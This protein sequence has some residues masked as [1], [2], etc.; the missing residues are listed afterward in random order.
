[1]KKLYVLIC[2]L[3]V[4]GALTAQQQVPTAH[5]QETS[6]KT[7][8]DRSN[9]FV[10][11][12]NRA[13]HFAEDFE[14][15]T[16]PPT[17]WTVQ[18]GATSTIT[19]PATQTWHDNANG[20]PGQCASVLYDN[21][22][23]IHDEWLMTPAI[24]I[25]NSGGAIRLEF[26][27]NTSQFWH[28]NPNDNADIKCFVS[29]VGGTI[30]DLAAGTEVFWEQDPLI[31]NE[32]ATFEWYTYQTDFTAYAGQTV[33][34]GWH[35]LGQDGAQFNLD[36]ISIYDVPPHDLEMRKM[37]VTDI[38]ADWEIRQYDNA[39]LRPIGLTGIIANNGG[40]AQTN[41]GFDYIIQDGTGGTVDQGSAAVTTPSLAPGAIDT[42]I[43][44][45]SYTPPAG[46]DDYTVWLIATADSV[47]SN[48]S[49]DSISRGF[50]TATNQW[51]AENG[52]ID[53]GITNIGGG[54]GL[55]V[56]FGNQMIATGDRDY[57]GVWLGFG[58]NSAAQTGELAYCVLY[59]F[60]TNSQDFIFVNQTA[61]YTLTGNE[62]GNYVFLPWDGGGFESITNGEQ[63]LLTAAHYGG[64][65][66]V[67]FGTSGNSLEGQVLG[68][69]DQNSL[70]Q[71]LDP[72]TI[73]VRLEGITVS[74]EENE[75][76]VY[77]GQSIPN[78]ATNEI[79]IPYDMANSAQVSLTIFDITGKIVM[80]VNKG[81]QPAGTNQF[82]LNVSN[83]P[84]GTYTYTLTT[85]D[86]QH[87]KRMV[88]VR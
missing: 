53:G 71:L 41:V 6:A 52:P 50:S 77:L 61:D 70:F 63:Y 83:L 75:N 39:Q 37:Y 48:S 17:G 2:G 84:S 74:I 23:D 31:V 27:I 34:L 42:V 68:Y 18:S 22:V 4:S 64:N 10:V 73:A 3:T 1:M 15:G 86:V 25:P 30:T 8:I 49:N 78:P 59:R 46:V 66:D 55:P 44:Q 45:T 19:V 43:F 69:D 88:I 80:E 35:Y 29:T 20:N 79:M 26:Q 76:G 9:A 28:V 38:D 5:A 12:A 13:T 14:S 62:A 32:W 11:P 54:T 67:E 21:S 7:G 85:D 57:S 82:N 56:S 87:S 36:N 40:V 33:Y 24:T 58:P 51:G 47:D 72:P 81:N 16:Y 65:N 60:D